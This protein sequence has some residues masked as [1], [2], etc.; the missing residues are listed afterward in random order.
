MIDLT[1]AIPVIVALVSAFKV[2]GLDSK[3]APILAVLLGLAG[4]ALIGEGSMA[5]NLFE[6]VVA[7]L[8]ASGLYSGV[9]KSTEMVQ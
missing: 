1:I 2:A 9:I 3:F 4:F 8:S 6:G 7:G 5:A